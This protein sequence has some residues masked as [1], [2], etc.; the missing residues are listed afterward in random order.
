[1]PEIPLE[2]RF[3]RRHR[4]KTRP[5]AAPTAAPFVIL[6]LSVDIWLEDLRLATPSDS[7]RSSYRSVRSQDR[8]SGRRLETPSDGRGRP[9]R[10][11]HSTLPNQTTGP[12]KQ[13]WVDRNLVTRA[14]FGAPPG[15]FSE[16]PIL[17]TSSRRQKHK[18]NGR[19]ARLNLANHVPNAF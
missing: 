11:R 12:V 10:S 8:V 17:V 15:A 13:R 9:P 5:I 3:N 6:E 14:G 19:D 2:R 18:H 16:V 1:M 7:S 4:S